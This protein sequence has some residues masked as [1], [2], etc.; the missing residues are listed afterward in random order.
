MR[1]I[2]SHGLVSHSS[3]LTIY[4]HL[5][6]PFDVFFFGVA[7]V[8]LKKFRLNSELVFQQHHYGVLVVAVTELLA[9][10]SQQNRTTF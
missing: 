4:F 2:I 1:D 9:S 8:F 10:R 3:L 5:H 6:V 7:I